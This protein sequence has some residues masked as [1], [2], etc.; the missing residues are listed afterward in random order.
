[1]VAAALLGAAL[2]SHFAVAA[3]NPRVA[4]IGVR[5]FGVAEQLVRRAR[6]AVVTALRDQSLEVVDLADELFYV[7]ETCNEGLPYVVHLAPHQAT[8]VVALR[9]EVRAGGREHEISVSV[10]SLGVDGSRYS[11]PWPTST[12]CRECGDSE[13]VEATRLLTGRAWKAFERASTPATEVSAT[14]RERADKGRA[15]VRAAMREETSTVEQ[16]Y[17]LKRAVRAGAGAEAFSRLAE[18]FYQ[19]EQWEDAESYALRAAAVGAD[20]QGVLGA[21]YYATGRWKD[22]AEVLEVRLRRDPSNAVTAKVLAEVKRR[23]AS[24]KDI[25]G[26]AEEALARGDSFEAKRLGRMAVAVAGSDPRAYLVVA[27]AAI[28]ERD[29][30]DAWA[31]Y[32]RAVELDP[33]NT[34]AIAGRRAASESL[35]REVEKRRQAAGR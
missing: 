14:A 16:I 15:L 2:T 8:H 12:I 32:Q 6:A 5:T 20:I 3:G 23:L 1:V 30:C 34:R 28:K 9:L 18:L 22:A 4:L 25:V 35:R 10:G 29:V 13:I 26:Q 7:S 19:A 24:P 31:Y 33:K 27:D 11:G 17:L 21:V